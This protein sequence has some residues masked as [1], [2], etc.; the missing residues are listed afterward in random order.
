[1]KR[2]RLRLDRHCPP[3]R[4]I[5]PFNNERNGNYFSTER[6]KN[7]VQLILTDHDIVLA[8]HS[9][10]RKIESHWGSPRSSTGHH[11]TNNGCPADR[12]HQIPVERQVVRVRSRSEIYGGAGVIGR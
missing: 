6:T 7:G 9:D 10:P 11:S 3:T 4:R 5:G 1:M 8:I 12:E 2:T